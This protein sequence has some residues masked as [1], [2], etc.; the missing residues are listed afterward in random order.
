MPKINIPRDISHAALSAFAAD[1]GCVLRYDQVTGEY[2]MIYVPR[3]KPT[4]KVLDFPGRPRLD[5]TPTP[6]GAA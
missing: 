4:A 5:R 6:P 3:P 2:E 1:Q